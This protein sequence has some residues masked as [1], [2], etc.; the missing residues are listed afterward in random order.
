MSNSS[1]LPTEFRIIGESAARVQ[2]LVTAGH[3]HQP[4]NLPRGVISKSSSERQN[5]IS[6][7]MKKLVWP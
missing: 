6:N 4:P 3:R 1:F 5:R 2:R 7:S